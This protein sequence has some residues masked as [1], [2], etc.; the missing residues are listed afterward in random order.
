M[1]DEE[2]AGTASAA[3]ESVEGSLLGLSLK[4]MLQALIPEEAREKEG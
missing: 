4:K 3:V 1:A 2:I